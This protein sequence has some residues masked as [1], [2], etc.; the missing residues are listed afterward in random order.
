MAAT[1]IADV[2]IPEIFNPYV[3]QRT[4]ELS[5]LW[6]SGIIAGVSDV[7]LGD[8]NNQK[9]GKTVHMPFWNDLTGDDQLLTTT[10]DLT[11]ANITAAQDIAVLNA[12]A[13]V[14]GAK[15]L[16]SALA[17][18]DPMTVIG[19]LLAAKWARQQQKTLLAVLTGAFG[20]MAAESPAYGTLNISGLSGAAAYF[21]ADS[22]I[23]ALGLLGDA[24]ARLTGML[25]HSDTF[26]SMKKQNLI[27]FIPDSRGEVTIPTYLGKQVV[28]DDGAPVS[29][30]NYTTYLFGPGAIGYSEGTPLV[31]TE[32][33]RDPLIGGGQGY[34]VSRRHFVL[35][36]RG[37]AWVGSSSAETPTNVELAT[38]NKYDRVWE[39]KNVRMVR[40]I[41]KLG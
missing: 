36:P 21:D 41:H 8:A 34:L 29:A 4:A 6:T 30:G 19:D 20:A 3:I 24:E 37:I 28:V 17:G 32:T 40:F 11:I 1:T 38:A 2:I 5:A 27:D 23:D 22:V 39:K 14:Y 7:D 15:D 13:L 18:D 35:H 31:P 25:I 9:G 12:R 10:A 26:R 33:F 16:V